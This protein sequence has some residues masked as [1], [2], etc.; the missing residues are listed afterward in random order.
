MGSAYRKPNFS[1]LIKVISTMMQDK[2]ML[3]LFPLTEISSQIIS[4]KALLNM[5]LDPENDTDGSLAQMA[6]GNL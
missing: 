5:L 4:S 1:S 6:K 2:K 3:E